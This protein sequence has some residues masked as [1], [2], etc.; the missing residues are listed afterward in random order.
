MQAHMYA[1]THTRFPPPPKH[2]HTQ[3]G[4]GFTQVSLN[5]FIDIYVYKYIFS[6][7]NT[8][9]GEHACMRMQV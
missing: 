6:L 3:V 4:M 1:Q 5:T 8:H 7:K 9:M 2:K